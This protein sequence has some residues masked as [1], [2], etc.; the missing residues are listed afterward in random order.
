MGA[1]GKL[2]VTVFAFV[3]YLFDKFVILNN[4]D[5]AATV[6]QITIPG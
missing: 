2:F 3:L 6:N 4:P 1:K 5:R